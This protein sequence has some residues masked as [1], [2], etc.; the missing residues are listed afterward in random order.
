MS[1]LHTLTKRKK[2]KKKKKINC[3]LK[4]EPESVSI[5]SVWNKSF[6]NWSL[7]YFSMN[8]NQCIANKVN[9]IWNL[10]YSPHD[11]VSFH[12]SVFLLRSSYSCY[13]SIFAHHIKGAC[14]MNLNFHVLITD[15]PGSPNT[16]CV[17]FW[18]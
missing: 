15:K 11:Y 12:L 7:Y 8:Q 18:A 14:F 5:C 3:T 2:K 16:M 17:F 1:I 13:F 9:K 10:L 4:L 6:V